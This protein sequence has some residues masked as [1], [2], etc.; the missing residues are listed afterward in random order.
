MKVFEANISHQVST[1][2]N[3]NLNGLSQLEAANQKLFKATGIKHFFDD[4]VT[5]LTL[6]EIIADTYD[7][8]EEPDREE[9]GDFQTNMNLTILATNWLNGQDISPNI[10]IEPTCGKGNFI[11]AA[12][13]TYPNLEKIIGV[14]IYLPYI[15]E[16]KFNIIEFY[17]SNPRDEK[18][19]IEI[20]HFN[21][22]DFDFKQVAKDCVKK[23]VLIIGN[24]P[25]VTNAKLGGLESDNLPTKSNFKK[26]S[27]LDAMTGK[28]NFDIGEYITLMMFD[29]FQYS[30][31]YFAFLVKNAVIKNVVFDQK[32]RS[33]S[34]AN[35][36]KLTIDSKKE[37]NVSVEAALFFCQLNKAPEY[38]CTEFNF[39]AHSRNLTALPVGSF[40]WV[41][42]KFV[43]DIGHYGYSSDIDG[44]CP[45][46][47]RQG[48]KHDLSS[49]MEFERVNG[50]YVNGLQEEIKLEEDL[51]YGMLKSSDL[52]LTVIDSTRK[53]TIITQKK[54]GQDTSFIKKRFPETY[55]YLLRNK[56]KFDLRKSS[57]YNNKPDYSIFGIGDYSFAPYK[58]TIS[59]LY[60]TYSFNLVMPQN[61]KP[62]MLDDTC[63]LLG[64][65]NIEFAAYTLILLNSEKT[66]AL[67]KSIT[68][69][70]AKRV[71][72]KDILMRIDLYKLA[73]QVSGANV[74]QELDQLNTNY[75][76]SVKFDKWHDFIKAMKPAVKA[77]QMSMFPT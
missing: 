33:Y 38:T 35:L 63:Y 4:G 42:D 70:D 21:V 43:S 15:W 17:L 67:L 59:G 69:P 36:Q 75:N 30:N 52:K 26:H 45:F 9:Y 29:A 64:F 27:G 40:G 57:I 32:Q 16:T 50:H 47:W 41:G 73:L 23:E 25:W 60:K 74:H 48:V 54:V 12:L 68:F 71:F 39:Y 72:T 11:I 34:I 18:P 58:I 62:L 44:V 55:A 28:G 19:N 76:L 49:I 8:V 77:Q 61:G 22:F 5:F 51:V 66:E 3:K 6:K 53:Y 31:G 13:Q 10:V 56:S 65:D 14:E 46:E 7:V 2:L 37:F 1:F 20:N 24:P